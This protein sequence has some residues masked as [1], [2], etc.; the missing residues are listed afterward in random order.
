M[1][2]LYSTRNGEVYVPQGKQV[3]GTT[4]GLRSIMTCHYVAHPLHATTGI[5]KIAFIPLI[6]CVLPNGPSSTGKKNKENI[7][8]KDCYLV[9]DHAEKTNSDNN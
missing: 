4:V 1:R 8:T 5:T 9:C 7:L 3:F 6:T 2:G